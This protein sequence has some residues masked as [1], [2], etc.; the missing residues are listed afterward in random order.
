MPAD[1][2]PQS[3]GFR[4]RAQGC[5]PAG[6]RIARAADVAH[7]RHR[8]LQGIQRYLGAYD[9][10]PGAAAGSAV[11]LGERQRPR[12]R[13]PLWRRGIRSR[14]AQHATR[15]CGRAGQPDPALCGHVARSWSKKSTGEHSGNDL[16]FNPGRP[17][18]SPD[19][20]LVSFVQRAD[21]CLYAAKGAGPAIAS[22]ATRNQRWARISSQPDP[23]AGPRCVGAP[24]PYAAPT[25]SGESN[26]EKR[27]R[28]RASCRARSPSPF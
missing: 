2:N 21:T 17:E 6:A 23:S 11:S 16:D 14:P 24:S 28:T 26:H 25:T 1:G 8:S 19:D 27:I 7:V 18:F 22:S 9:R 5:D 4:C 15:Q 10:R 20:S 13:S 3:Q 12:H